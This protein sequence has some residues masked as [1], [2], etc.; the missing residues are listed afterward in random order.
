M[1]FDRAIRAHMLLRCTPADAY[2]A[3]ADPAITTRFWFDRASGPLLPGATVRWD[4]T[5]SGVGTDITVQAAEPGRLLR[6]DW[7]DPGE[8]TTVTW[9][10]DAHA[11]GCLV[12]IRETGFAGDVDALVP[13]MLDSAGGFHLV[14]AA[15]KAWLEH[16]IVLRVVADHVPPADCPAGGVP[17]E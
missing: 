1:S 6:V 12:D 4:W 17:A 11:D 9:T 7:G 14:L 5:M 2:A 13:R 8:R 3:F 15:A 10:F 16:G